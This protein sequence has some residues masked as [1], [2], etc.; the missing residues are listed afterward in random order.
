MP[1]PLSFVIY[2]LS[3]SFTISFYATTFSASFTC[4]FYPCFTSPE[5]N[6]KV[7]LRILRRWFY[8]DLNGGFLQKSWKILQ[9]FRHR[10]LHNLPRI[11]RL[12][13]FHGLR[14]VRIFKN[15]NSLKIWDFFSLSTISESKNFKTQEI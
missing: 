4:F 5:R 13:Q 3:F 11:L 15:F 1:I 14:I 6:Q 12:E 9:N 8:I 7:F 10:E 2:K